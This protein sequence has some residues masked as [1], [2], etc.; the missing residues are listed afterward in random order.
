MPHEHC[1]VWWL[2]HLPVQAIP[3]PDHPFTHPSKKQKYTVRT[4]SFDCGS[5]R[6]S[7]SAFQIQALVRNWPC[8]SCSCPETKGFTLLLKSYS[9]IHYSHYPYKCLILLNFA[10]LLALV[11]SCEVGSN[12]AVFL[13]PFLWYP[14]VSGSQIYW[15]PSLSFL[16][17]KGSSSVHPSPLAIAKRA[18]CL[19][20]A[21]LRLGLPANHKGKSWSHEYV[22]R[23]HKGENITISKQNNGWITWANYYQWITCPVLSPALKHSDDHLIKNWRNK[24]IFLNR[25]I[26]LKLLEG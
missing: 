1:Q 25:N 3:V 15:I 26:I 7:Y 19:T 5:L 11:T 8:K 14:V 6:H 17:D 24:F 13:R 20:P 10:K 23:W 2:H 18:R 21:G 4:V 12:V 16:W 9:K 22:Q